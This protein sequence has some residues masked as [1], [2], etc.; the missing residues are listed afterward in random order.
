MYDGGLADSEFRWIFDRDKGECTR[1]WSFGLHIYTEKRALHFKL[2]S[3]MS[4]T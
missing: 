4:L 1:A 2:M 3:C